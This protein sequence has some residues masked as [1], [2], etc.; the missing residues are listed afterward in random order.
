M[1]TSLPEGA[2]TSGINTVDPIFFG[3][4]SRKKAGALAPGPA[5]H[6]LGAIHKD[7]PRRNGVLSY[8]SNWLHQMALKRPRVAPRWVSGAAAE[9]SRWHIWTQ[10]RE[11][12]A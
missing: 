10:R 8:P 4:I 12:E 7:N 6:A 3:D 9:V 5:A 1:R 11:R 2:N